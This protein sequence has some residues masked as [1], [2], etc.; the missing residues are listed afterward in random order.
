MQGAAQIV[1]LLFTTVL[2]LIPPILLLV[3][4]SKYATLE[5]NSIITHG[6]FMLF[7][8]CTILGTAVSSYK[9]LPIKSEGTRHLIHGV[10]S[11]ASL[12]FMLIGWSHI[13]TVTRDG[14]G[15]HS[16]SGHGH[17]HDHSHDHYLSVHNW[18]GVLTM[19][20][21]AITYLSAGFFFNPF[22]KIKPSLYMAAAPY[23]KS[24]GV[25]MIL[26]AAAATT[27]GLYNY[28]EK[29][30]PDIYKSSQTPALRLILSAGLFLGLA[31]FVLMFSLQVFQPD[32]KLKVNPL[33]PKTVKV[34][35]NVADASD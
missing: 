27:T 18:L 31:F 30:V 17:S 33:Q 21:F 15:G 10:L 23:H 19:I 12:V 20:V 35:E 3:Y 1:R 14:N 2:L 16:H 25:G 26:L 4:G 6:I 8:M 5:W 13:Y 32:S 7:G 11:T 9:N 29:Y 24:A 28:T 34:S 22:L